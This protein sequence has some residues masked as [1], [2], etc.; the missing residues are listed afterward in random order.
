MNEYYENVDTYTGKDFNSMYGDLVLFKLLDENDIDQIDEVYNT[1]PVDPEKN[2]ELYTNLK[3]GFFVYPLHH[4]FK[5]YH[6]SPS[7]VSL[8]RI[9]VPT[10]AIIW[11]VNNI[12]RVSKYKI[13]FSVDA[14]I[15]YK[16]LEQYFV[17]EMMN[18]DPK[19]SKINE[20]FI[21]ENICNALIKKNPKYFSILPK[22]Y[23]TIENFLFALKDNPEIIEYIPDHLVNYLNITKCLLNEEKSFKF[24]ADELKIPYICIFMMNIN[25]QMIHFVPFEKRCETVCR[26]CF[27]EDPTLYQFFPDDKKTQEMSRIIVGIDPMYLEFVPIDHRTMELCIDAIRHNTYCLQYIPEHILNKR[28]YMYPEEDNTQYSQME[29]IIF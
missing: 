11:K 19:I 13:V 26:I 1:P 21:N 17:N 18:N 29:S 14:K 7:F 10:D 23:Q 5:F 15:A 9:I 3:N 24:L 4:L 16:K 8:S 12:V 25:A 20:N 22:E 2:K 6:V 27:K 28:S